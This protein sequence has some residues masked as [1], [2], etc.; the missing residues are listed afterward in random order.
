MNGEESIRSS[1]LLENSAAV[2][3][4]SR[5]KTIMIV[6]GANP[7]M[8]TPR[9][10]TPWYSIIYTP[11]RTNQTLKRLTALCIKRTNNIPYKSKA[12]N[13]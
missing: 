10:T 2:R 13:P 4:V 6:I 1:F 8:R 3:P 7:D 9:K 12:V 11:A 5:Q